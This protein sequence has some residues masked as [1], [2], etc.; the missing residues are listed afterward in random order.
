MTNKH[1][2][3]DWEALAAKEAKGADLSRQTP[4]GIKIKTVYG[5]GGVAHIDSGYPGLP[6]YTR[7]P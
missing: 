3:D 7:G 1:T 4:E 5:P 6:P 2:R